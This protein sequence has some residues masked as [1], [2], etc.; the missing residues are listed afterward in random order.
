MKVHYLQHVPFENAANIA[1][2]AKQRGHTLTVTRFHEDEPLPDIAEI[3]LLAVMGG[4]MNVYQHQ[5]YA[6]LTREKAF[7]ERAI[8]ASVPTIGVCLGAQLLANVLGAKV[9]R[10]PYVEIGWHAVRLTRD[11]SRSALFGALP[12]E[13]TAFHWHGDTFDL[14]AG[15]AHLAASDA[16]VHQAFEYGARIL[17]LQF[18][19]EYSTGSIEAMLAQ[20]GDELSDA[21]FVQTPDQIRAG[22]THVPATY[23]LLATLLDR[24]VGS[25]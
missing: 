4:P 22:Y 19:L 17:G 24:L 15:A 7:L 1:L 16:C 21:P 10:N 14:P 12:H 11:A 23:H 9:A 6:W 20:C 5:E 3:D 2:W 25:P 8:G 18:H 13:F